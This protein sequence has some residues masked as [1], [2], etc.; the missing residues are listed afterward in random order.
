MGLKFYRKKGRIVTT[1]HIAH[2]DPQFRQ[3][4][5]LKIKDMFKVKILKFC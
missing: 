2:I 3:L 1:A 4:N 5:V